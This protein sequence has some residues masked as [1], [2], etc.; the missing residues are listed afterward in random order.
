MAKRDIG[1]LNHYLR[2]Q[3]RAFEGLIKKIH[4]SP[5]IERVHK[6]RVTARRILTVLW[7]LKTDP[8]IINFRKLSRSLRQ[9]VKKLGKLRE[10]DVAIQ[11]SATYG[12]TI[13]HLEKRRRKSGRDM[14]RYLVVRRRS[15]LRSELNIMARK[16]SGLSNINLTISN[17]KLSGQVKFWLRGSMVSERDLHEFRTFIKKFRYV[18]EATGRSIS[19]LPK[20][21]DLLGKSHDLEVLQQFQGKNRR[22]DR[23]KVL[24]RNKLRL[25]EK[26]ILH[27]MA[28]KLSAANSR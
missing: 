9:L 14:Q 18:M 17:R 19:S 27:S 16:V 20:L 5:S 1:E 23:D 12:L 11:D 24:V 2:I 21:Q 28:L 4:Q 7:L 22:I 13:K 8:D 3:I 15:K 26:R 6:L 10:L 25:A